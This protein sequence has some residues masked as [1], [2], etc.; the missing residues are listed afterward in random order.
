MASEK[1]SPEL[2]DD[3]E[4]YRRMSLAPGGFGDKR[5]DIWCKLV[6]AEPQEPGQPA[7]E[8]SS[9]HPDERQIRLDTERSF[10]LYPVDSK[11]NK[12]TLQSELHDLL[13][14]IFRKRPKLNYF[15]G[16]HDIITVLLLTLPP[17]LQLPVAEQLSLQRVRDSMGHTLEPVLGLLRVM[18]NLIRA[19]D[20][21]YA[22]LLERTSPLPYYALP[23]LLTLFSHDM[24]TLPLIQHVFDYLLCRPPI[25]VVYL[26]STIILSRKQDVQR[27]EEEG[28]E[29]MMHSI[30]SA[31]PEIVEENSAEDILTK[32]E[33]PSE[34]SLHEI[35]QDPS[36][37]SDLL[38]EN[39]NPA[40]TDKMTAELNGDLSVSQDD[41]VVPDI[42]G[43]LTDIKDEHET[44]RPS[45]PTSVTKIEPSP[46][47]PF[48]SSIEEPDSVPQS[49]RRKVSRPKPYTL[50]EILNMTDTLYQNHAPT[51]PSLQ[52][53]SIM[54][55]QSVVFT[56][57]THPSDMPSSEEAERM[58]DHVELIVYPE[59]PVVESKEKSTTKRRPKRSK[60]RKG[61]G[62][63]GLLVG[64][65]LV[66][67][68]A[69]AV[70]VYGARQGGDHTRDW[71]KLGRWVGGVLA[72]A[73][74][75]VVRYRT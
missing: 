46:S 64:A 54:G 17:E 1:A 36:D 8:E 38:T 26:A 71:R 55:P 73:S 29:G 47:E 72:G 60:R 69:V 11:T 25:F 16:Y 65:G 70:S 30:L 61:T 74:E 53:S 35:K 57:S 58:V 19:A 43:P 41:P 63:V 51:D 23:N 15:Q 68:V 39:L 5:V 42:A 10:V 67:G 7:D 75:R 6:H 33:P 22:E 37:D 14:K 9:L 27:L 24:P 56:W 18:K 20:P 45:S 62:T 40:H 52:V 34:D 3:W 13:V 48:D 31:L 50:T 66:L 59:P 2:P 4:E 44:D 12:D 49:N 21:K 28:E 32:E